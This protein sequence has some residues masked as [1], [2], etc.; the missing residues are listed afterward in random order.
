M[1]LVNLFYF[2]LGAYALMYL[3][4][5]V[6]PL[7]KALSDLRPGDSLN[8][9]GALLRAE[10]DEAAA[11]RRPALATSGDGAVVVAVPV[12]GAFES[13]PDDPPVDEAD[14]DEWY[15][16]EAEEEEEAVAPA[17]TSQVVAMERLTGHRALVAR[18]PSPLV[19]D[20]V[21][22]V[23]AQYP[24]GAY[25]RVDVERLPS[26]VVYAERLGTARTMAGL[27]V[28][29]GLVL[30]MTKLNSVVGGIAGVTRSSTTQ[31]GFLDA[32]SRL[33]QDIGGAF[34][35]SIWGLW[36]MLAALAVL[37]II[38]Q[39]AQKAVAAVDREFSGRVVPDLAL[40]HQSLAPDLSLGDLLAKTGA[41][42]SGLNVTVD[43]LT[44][45][46]AASLAE[47]GEQIRDML[48][49]FG[50]FEKHYVQLSGLL[51]E[52]GEAGETLR[53]VTRGLDGATQ[54]LAEPLDDFNRNVGEHLALVRSHLET[55]GD[56]TTA[57]IEGYHETSTQLQTVQAHS[58]ETVQAI[59]NL[60][61]TR[62]DGMGREQVE[63]LR[64][65]QKQAQ[66][67]NARLAT[68]I[69][70]LEKTPPRAAPVARHS[71]LGAEGGL[72]PTLFLWVAGGVQRL[73]A[74]VRQQLR[75]R[76]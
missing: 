16:E 50:R 29:L 42:L 63:A 26:Y 17:R 51:R 71:A 44:R 15:D 19:Q 9:L 62:I 6:V 3:V 75:S 20:A 5:F 28:L 58:D 30:T 11:A 38:D 4:A 22:R 13:D 47:L 43:G 52:I 31:Q 34:T 7:V 23:R 32:M 41:S 64:G 25:Q 55:V 65:F 56:A 67:T 57:Y 69:G 68:L 36:L 39:F 35:A 61:T 2:I 14:D 18:Y 33:M 66:E 8:R 48:Q 10:A 60:L 59:Q 21:D 27:F 54:R 37:A 72:P 24:G 70:V 49:D 45:G 46:M 74:Y 73:V 1:G 40:L 53:S 12:S 76:R